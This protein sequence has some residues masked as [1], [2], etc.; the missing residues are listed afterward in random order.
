M[1][2]RTDLALELRDSIKSEHI[3]GILS[4]QRHEEYNILVTN[5]EVK[6]EIGQRT[7]G[8]PIGKYVTIEATEVLN[9]DLEVEDYIAKLLSEELKKMLPQ[10]EDY[11][12]LV[13]G[14]GNRDITPDALGCA[15][16]ESLMVTRH[17][18]E[19]LPRE[20]QEDVRSV[21]AITPGV[22]GV[23]GIESASIVKSI[24]DNVKPKVVVIID[25][26]A[27]KSTQRIGT[28]FQ[29]TD[30]GISPGSGVGNKRIGLNTETLGAKVIAIGVPMV[31]YTSTIVNDIILE[32]AQNSVKEQDLRA[33]VEGVL[34]QND[35]VV[36]PKEIDTMIKDVS[37][38]IAKSLN[39]SLHKSISQEFID[40]ITH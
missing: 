10:D 40:Q 22:L 38:I 29:I 5:V 13:V 15:T 1:A 20:V 4:T 39:M 25:S 2:I 23:T 24:V 11:T 33:L 27:S 30:T 7:I 31:V 18:R 21:C 17:I 32:M 9:R 14:L 34:P 6:S 8:K 12:T 36:T 26:L 28:T 37:G 16:A 19:Y 3:P 35:M